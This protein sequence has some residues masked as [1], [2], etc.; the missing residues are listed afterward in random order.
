MEA[1]RNYKLLRSYNINLLT[2][3]KIK[4]FKKIVNI[5][6]I[7]RFYSRFKRLNK[8]FVFNHPFNINFKIYVYS[9]E[10]NALNK[11]VTLFIL[12]LNKFQNVNELVEL[13]IE[14][15]WKQTE[16]QSICERNIFI[17]ILLFVVIYVSQFGTSNSILILFV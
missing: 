6:K 4:I 2:I 8:I 10:I 15:L 7:N 16:Q 3:K 13:K 9:D 12:N 1:T 11:N 14:K 5:W 17:Y